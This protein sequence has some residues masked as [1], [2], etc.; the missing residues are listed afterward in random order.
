[1]ISISLFEHDLRAN[2]L[3]LS[4]GN[5]FPLSGIMLKNKNPAICGG[6]QSGGASLRLAVK[7][8]SQAESALQPHAARAAR[9]RGPKRFL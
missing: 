9:S 1:M 4:R 6:V 8:D 5:R 7:L 2:A 3:R